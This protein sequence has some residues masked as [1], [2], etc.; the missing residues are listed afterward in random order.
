MPPACNLP[1]IP[2][3]VGS[4]ER[5]TGRSRNPEETMKKLILPFALALLSA[6]LPASAEEVVRSFQKQ[7]P[8]G[9]LND[10]H[11]EIPVGEVE[12]E[13]SDARQVEVKVDL[14]CKNRKPRCLEAARDVRFV[15]TTD[16]GRLHLQ[17]KD[18]PK[19][20]TKGL[21][22]RAKFSVPKN[23][24][25]KAELG[26]GELTIQGIENDLQVDLGVGEVNMTLPEAAVGS[27]SLD[28]GIGEASLKAG[29]RR[30]ESA[31]LF[32]REVNW[33]QGKGQAR[34]SV[35]CGVGEI[36]VALQ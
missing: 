4:K 22:A 14:V 8:V 13:A 21:Q 10:I 3:V 24:A 28:T 9:D 29:G 18:W 20:G 35:D 23:L 34:V 33:N 6:A 25:L 17:M 11:I 2:L 1:R 31:G 19:A 16:D 30:Y 12:I 36:N 5:Q 26:V 27:V 7:F 15:Y 32:V